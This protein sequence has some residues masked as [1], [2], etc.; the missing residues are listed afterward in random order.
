MSGQNIL[1]TQ[2]VK[3]TA[4]WSMRSDVHDFNPEEEFAPYCRSHHLMVATSVS[5]HCLASLHT[6]NKNML[7]GQRPQ[8]V[9]LE[10]GLH[11]ACVL[12]LA[13]HVSTA[14]Q[15]CT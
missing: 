5:S 12:Y 6:C 13:D 7:Q 2:E 14:V 11:T 8:H 10:K 15:A 1:A 9:E 3:N 4:Y